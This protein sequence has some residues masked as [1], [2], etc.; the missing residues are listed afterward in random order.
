MGLRKE[1]F[2]LT[3][4]EKFLFSVDKGNSSAGCWLWR[5][6]KTG[7]KKAYG[8]ICQDG[9]RWLAHRRAWVLFK[10]PIPH[11]LSVLH[12]CDTPAC[13]NPDHLFIGTTADNMKD[14]QSKGRGRNGPR[15]SGEQNPNA[16]LTASAVQS[17]RS[18]ARTC[19]AIA[20]DYGVSI[21]LISQIRRRL[22]WKH[23]E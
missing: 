1:L 4:E 15:R 19:T 5:G 13:V 9:V 23:V 18:D 7:S 10:G 16:R 2:S 20:K 6:Y 22:A 3:N 11:G 8:E 14:M 12:K 21:F 17:I